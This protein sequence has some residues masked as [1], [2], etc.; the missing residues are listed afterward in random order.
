MEYSTTV[1]LKAIREA[2]KIA[3]NESLVIVL[4]SLGKYYVT[5]DFPVI[6][7][8]TLLVKLYRFGKDVK[9]E[10]T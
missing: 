6:G 8:N 9:F 10:H 5:N 3:K 4:Q 7:D 2:K 1:R